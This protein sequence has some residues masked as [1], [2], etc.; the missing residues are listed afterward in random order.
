MRGEST[1][2]LVFISAILF[3]KEL[4]NIAVKY[5][6]SMIGERIRVNLSSQLS[7]HAIEKFCLINTLFSR[8]TKTRPANCKPELIAAR[9]V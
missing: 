2:L 1:S 5:G 4:L 7:Q 6:Q 3:G 8:R 9:T